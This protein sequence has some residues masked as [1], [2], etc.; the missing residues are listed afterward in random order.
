MIATV[1]VM[2][3]DGEVGTG[4]ILPEGAVGGAGPSMSP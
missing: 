2:G 3:V 1:R 4:E